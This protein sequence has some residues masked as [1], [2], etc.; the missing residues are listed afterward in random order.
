LS[1][2]TTG[3]IKSIQQNYKIRLQYNKK[4]AQQNLFNEKMTNNDER[5]R[6]G[7]KRDQSPKDFII[8]LCKY[9]KENE[10]SRRKERNSKEFIE[11]CINLYE[12]QQ[13]LCAITGIK[14]THTKIPRHPYNI[15][16]D[17]IDNDRGY[18]IGNVRLL[19]LYINDILSNRG[20][21][22]LLDISYHVEKNRTALELQ[23]I[24]EKQRKREH[25]E[26]ET[27]STTTGY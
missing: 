22:V 6:L 23:V 18:E 3:G 8:Y 17:R 11:H 1:Q 24:R 27:N 5:K 13:G 26:K 7:A 10:V 2:S 16:I 4:T 21:E 12:Q 19:C 15:S 14:M 25:L 20:L 9:C